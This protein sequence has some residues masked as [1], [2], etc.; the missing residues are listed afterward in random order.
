MVIRVC[1]LV[2]VGIINVKCANHNRLETT[3]SAKILRKYWLV[4]YIWEDSRK[5]LTSSSSCRAC[6]FVATYGNS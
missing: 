4:W 5:E 6:F 3:F 1:R 2:G